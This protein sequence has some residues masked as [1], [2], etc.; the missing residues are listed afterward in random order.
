MAIKKLWNPIFVQPIGLSDTLTH[1]QY[2][3]V[4]KQAQKLSDTTKVALLLLQQHLKIVHSADQLFWCLQIAQELAI[5]HE[6]DNQTIEAVINLTNQQGDNALILA[7]RH[8]QFCIALWLIS[9]NINTNVSNTCGETALILASWH[10][11]PDIIKELLQKQSDVSMVDSTGKTALDYAIK[12]H[13]T[14]IIQLLR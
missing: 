13:N 7:L 4:L 6:L 1:E 14:Q 11:R 5:L 8:E 12:N 9:Q 2:L 3:A 10:N